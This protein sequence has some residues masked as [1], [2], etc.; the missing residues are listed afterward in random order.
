M[1]LA[2]VGLLLP[3]SAQRALRNQEKLPARGV[4]C[5]ENIKSPLN[6]TRRGDHRAERSAVIVAGRNIDFGE[7]SR[8][9][10][11]ERE[12]FSGFDGLTH[13]QIAALSSIID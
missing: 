4:F 13:G 3:Q 11:G 9:D 7:L 6:N 5:G 2:N 10:F 12:S 1:L 8:A